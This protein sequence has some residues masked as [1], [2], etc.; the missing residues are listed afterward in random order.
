MVSHARI[1]EFRGAKKVYINFGYSKRIQFNQ[2]PD[3]QMG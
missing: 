1:P 3:G 2:I